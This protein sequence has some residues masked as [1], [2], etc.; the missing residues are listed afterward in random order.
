MAL[1][2][3]LLLLLARELC[4]M[5]LLLERPLH[6]QFLLQLGLSAAQMQVQDRH[7]QMPLL[8]GAGALSGCSSCLLAPPPAAAHPASACMLM[9]GMWC[10]SAVYLSQ[11]SQA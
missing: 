4:L 8:A 11:V 3:L 5:L 10:L 1:L 7:S 6:M 9:T 2:L